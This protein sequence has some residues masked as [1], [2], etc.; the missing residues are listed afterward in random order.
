MSE[1]PKIRYVKPDPLKDPWK[2]LREKPGVRI[3]ST[4]REE[5]P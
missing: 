4:A 3:L 2:K 1:K 5:V